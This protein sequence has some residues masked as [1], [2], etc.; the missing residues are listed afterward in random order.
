MRRTLHAATEYRQHLHRA[1]LMAALLLAGSAAMAQSSVTDAPRKEEARTAQPAKEAEPGSG[2]ELNRGV[3]Q[4][5]AKVPSSP[6]APAQRKEEPLENT[7][8]VPAQVFTEPEPATETP[9]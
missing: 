3:K 1:A 2:P 4:D 6:D 7:G 5:L 8:P 9:N